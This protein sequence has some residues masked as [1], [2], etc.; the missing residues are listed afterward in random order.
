M[1]RRDADDAGRIRERLRDP[2]LR[3]ALARRQGRYLLEIEVCH[4]R[5]EVLRVGPRPR[6][7]R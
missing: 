3:E 2:A 7:D 5:R 4:S 1:G 6:A